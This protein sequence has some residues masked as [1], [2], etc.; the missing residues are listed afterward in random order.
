LPNLKNG[1][2]ILNINF[3]QQSL[4]DPSNNIKRPTM[5][6][7]VSRREETVARRIGLKR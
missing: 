1:K 3:K 6:R 7:W 5:C 2:N 4:G